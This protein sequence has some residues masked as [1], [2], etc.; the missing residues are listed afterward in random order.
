MEKNQ[1]RKDIIKKRNNLDE[2]YINKASMQIINNIL[3]QPKLHDAKVV[4]SYMPFGNEADIMPLNQ[5]LLDNDKCLCIPRTKNGFQMDAV[6]VENLND[7]LIKNNYGIMEPASSV[8]A[9]E[10]E[11]IDLVLVPGVAFDK[12]GNRLGHGKGYYDRFLALCDEHT[13][14]WGIAYSFQLLDYIPCTPYDIMMHKV[15]TELE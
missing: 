2:K 1:L 9:I 10:I 14:F 15:I 13:D 6:I 4:F 5:W 3:S 11:K 12:Q 7:R 8:Q